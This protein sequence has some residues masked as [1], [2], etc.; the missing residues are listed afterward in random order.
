MARRRRNPAAALTS[1]VKAA[2]S[3][4]EVSALKQAGAIALGNIAT[5]TVSGMLTNKVS[6]LNNKVGKVVAT[7]ALA[8]VMRAVAGKVVPGMAKDI[9]IGGI[10]A[11]VTKGLQAVAPQYFGTAGLEDDD[12]GLDGMDDWLN[13]RGIATAQALTGMGDS[14]TAGQVQ[15]AIPLSDFDQDS[16]MDESM[17][18]IL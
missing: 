15:R 16:V 13:P 2:M 8:G 6:F 14:L 11:G 9:A 10:L 1:P 18:G 3:G 17:A 5:A 4:F 7:L 12:F